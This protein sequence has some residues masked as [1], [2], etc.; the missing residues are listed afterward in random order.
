MRRL[1]SS[2]TLAVAAVFAIGLGLAAEGAASAGQQK[3]SATNGLIAFM[4]PGQVGEYDLWVVRPNGRALR[5][6]TRAPAGRS[7][8]NPAW[9]PDGSRVLFERRKVDENAPGGD[10]A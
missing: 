10:E 6:L 1:T 2:W 5:R 4:R 3:A 8:Y 7:D 9:S